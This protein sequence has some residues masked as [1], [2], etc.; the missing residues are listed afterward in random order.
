MKKIHTNLDS[1]NFIPLVARNPF[2]DQRYLLAAVSRGVLLMQWYQPRH[3]FMHVKLYECSL[4]PQLPVFEAF[5]TEGEEYPSLCV[6]IRE[7]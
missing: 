4:P 1:F 3:A 2:T 5:V 6:G 7:V